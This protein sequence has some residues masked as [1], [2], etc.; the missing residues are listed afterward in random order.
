MVFDGNDV[1]LI[2]GAGEKA[3]TR[4]PFKSIKNQK[5]DKA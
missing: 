1:P 4:K 3:F 5:P 2:M